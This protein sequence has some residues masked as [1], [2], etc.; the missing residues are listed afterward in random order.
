MSKFTAIWNFWISFLV[1][2]CLLLTFAQERAASS[3]AADSANLCH[4]RSAKHIPGFTLI[5]SSTK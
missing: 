2:G 3:A 5:N 4:A 1:E